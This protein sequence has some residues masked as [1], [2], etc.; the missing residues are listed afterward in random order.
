MRLK[1][2]WIGTLLVAGALLVV[3]D[4]PA[5]L[6]DEDEYMPHALADLLAG[7]N[8]YETTHAQSGVIERPWGDQPYSWETAYPYLPMLLLL[9][10]PGIDFRWT[11]LFAYGALLVALR[12]TRWGF[13]AFANPMGVWFAASGFNDFA[14]LALL[15]WS[16]HVPW[17]AWIAAASKQF[18]L[19]LLAVEAILTREWRKLAGAVMFTAAICLPFVLWG[20]AAFVGGVAGAHLNKAPDWWSYWNYWLYLV[21]LVTVIAP[22][23]K[24]YGGTPHDARTA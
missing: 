23:R 22:A 1:V 13:W 5:T 4:W 6:T 17:L 9:Q 15:A 10:V 11:A 14:P 2:A 7:R 3:L 20:P 24:G 12:D 19:P 8:P 18:I 16:R 21:Y